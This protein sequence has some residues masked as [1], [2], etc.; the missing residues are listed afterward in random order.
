MKNIKTIL[1]YVAAAMS[2][3]QL[4]TS[5]D[6]LELSPIDYYGSGSYWTKETHISS[7]M[8]GM[9]NQLRSKAYQHMYTFGEARSGTFKTFGLDPV[10]Q[11]DINLKTQLVNKTNTVSKFGELYGLISNANLFIARTLQ[12]DYISEENKKY[13]LGQAYGLRA[14]YYFDLYRIYG[15]VPLRLIPDVVDGNINPSDLYMERS[16]PKQVMAQIKEDIQSSLDYFGNDKTIKGDKSYWSK[17]ATECLAGEVYLWTSKVTTGDNAANTADLTVAE[18]HLKNVMNDYGFS[19]VDFPDVFDV[20][21]KGNSEIIMTIRYAD[22]EASN[23]MGW[24][25]YSWTNNPALPAYYGEDGKLFGQNDTLK[26]AGSS[27]QYHQYKNGLYQSYDKEDTR[28]NATFLAAYSKENDELTL[29]GTYLRKNLGMWKEETGTR[30]FCGDWHIYR[31]PMVYLM[32]AEIENMKDGNPA[33]Y[34]NL[35]RQRAYGKNWD[36][37][38]FGY[39]NGDFTQ[40][41]LAIL[42]ERDKEFVLEGQRWFDICRMTFTKGG[43]PLVFHKEANYYSDDATETLLPI[44]D[45]ETQRHM[46]LWPIDLATQN[47]N[48]PKLE[49]TPGYED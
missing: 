25:A 11:L 32:L 26:L 31:L 49:Q 42:H 5:C 43:D 16:T 19:L 21:K 28:R 20:T 13:F 6:S 40:N 3:G 47:S 38:E 1:F 33:Y 44:L 30:V 24:F 39:K 34:I 35:V 4:A 36:E 27:L 10:T 46:V 17:A 45:K 23:S 9:H 41:E 14:F 7:F 22:K 37:A 29:A 18:T 8:D 12:A 48:V 2:L 15:G